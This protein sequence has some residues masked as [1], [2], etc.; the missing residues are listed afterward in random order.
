MPTTSIDPVVAKN[1]KDTLKRIGRTGYSVAVALR[2]QPNWLYQITS[3]KYSISIA[4]LREVADEI[5]VPV[6]SLIDLPPTDGEETNQE[7]P[8]G[9]PIKKHPKLLGR[10][11]ELGLRQASL[12]AYLEMS[13]T[14][15]NGILNGRRP[16]PE[17]FE[18]HISKT[19]D[20]FERAEHAAER[21]TAAGLS[22][23]INA[24]PKSGETKPA[25]SR[26]QQRTRTKRRRTKRR[27]TGVTRP[28]LHRRMDLNPP[29][30]SPR[31]GVVA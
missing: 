4:A 14:L 22:P 12:A 19:L 30:T 8:M 17:N 5:G 31:R 15:L 29:G 26:R 10:I 1:L 27:R 9:L 25:R 7:V 3:G 20:R 21:A 2:R 23:T 18:S 28:L 16:T 13:P 6:S 24:K 11:S